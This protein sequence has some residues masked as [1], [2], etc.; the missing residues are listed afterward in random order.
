[1]P[2]AVKKAPSA[3]YSTVA[4]PPSSVAIA[5]IGTRSPAGT[6]WPSVGL[7][8]V[9]VGGSVMTVSPVLKLREHVAPRPQLTVR[10]SDVEALRSPART[11]IWYSEF[12]SRQRRS[13]FGAGQ[14][15][16]GRRRIVKFSTTGS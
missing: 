11:V 14:G 3:E 5:W 13:A 2:S 8:I 15:V 10:G 4:I 7:E 16:T 12:C 9:I 1:L 6:D